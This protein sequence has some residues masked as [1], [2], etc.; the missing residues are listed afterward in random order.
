MLPAHGERGVEPGDVPG[1]MQPNGA[2]ERYQQEL[3]FHGLMAGVVA[4]EKS[5]LATGLPAKA[6]RDA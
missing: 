3:K 4:V 2:G 5:T 6:R 1:G